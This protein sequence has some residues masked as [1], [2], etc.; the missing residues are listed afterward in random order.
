MWWHKIKVVRVYPT[1]LE[2]RL[3]GSPFYGRRFALHSGLSEWT[4]GAQEGEVQN[5][6]FSAVMEIYV[7]I[8]PF[9]SF[10]S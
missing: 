7:E 9:G 1:T 2:P 8:D 3:E 10:S 5:S 4:V 6:F